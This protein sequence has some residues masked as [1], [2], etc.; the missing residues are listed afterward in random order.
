MVEV[1]IEK[2]FD[3]CLPDKGVALSPELDDVPEA[4]KKSHSVKLIE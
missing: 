2:A 1:G 4:L 3:N